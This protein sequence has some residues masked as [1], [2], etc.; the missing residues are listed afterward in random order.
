MKSNHETERKKSMST[1]A[2][3]LIASDLSVDRHL[4]QHYDG[5]PAEVLPVLALAIAEPDDIMQRIL[6]N[7]RH[8][9]ERLPDRPRRH[10]PEAAFTHVIGRQYSYGYLVDSF[11][12]DISVYRKPDDGNALRVSPLSFVP[13]EG[14]DQ[15]LQAI[16]SIYRQGWTLNGHREDV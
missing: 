13:R 15:V 3:Y 14:I 2:D 9:V 5:Y 4:Y 12:R 10:T 6:N 8:E 1:N 16:E 7:G 11:T